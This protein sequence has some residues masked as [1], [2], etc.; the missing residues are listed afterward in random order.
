VSGQ[1]HASDALPPGRWE[2]NVRMDLREMWWE[3]VDWMY[4][5]QDRDQSRYLVNTVLYIRVA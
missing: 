4:L 2:G 3:V 1:L 5:T